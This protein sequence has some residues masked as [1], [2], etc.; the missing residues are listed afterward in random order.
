[1]SLRRIRRGE[2]LLLGALAMLV[3]SLLLP[4]FGIEVPV[5]RDSTAIVEGRDGIGP[6]GRPWLD[7]VLL[8]GASWMV[9]LVLAARAGAGRS[10]YG[11]VTAVA[12]SLL[13]TV[14]V[15]IAT[16]V[17]ALT[18]S[19]DLAGVFGDDATFTL[20]ANDPVLTSDPTPVLGAAIGVGALLVAVAGL[21][22]ALADDRSRAAE[23]LAVDAPPVRDVPPLRPDP[24]AATTDA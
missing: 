14:V 7:L 18:A 8:A 6:L 17:R 24:A 20:A 10:T 23:S 19:P 12:V 2:L 16:A 1:V 5:E 4:W 3:G 11:A 13:L 9:V 22:M 21:W 15:A